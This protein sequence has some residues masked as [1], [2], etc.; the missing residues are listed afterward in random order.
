VLLLLFLRGSTLSGTAVLQHPPSLL[1]VG[2][3]ELFVREYSAV[4]GGEHF[5]RQITQRVASQG[6]VLLGA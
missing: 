2:G 3:D 4:L 1:Q 6:F 5:V